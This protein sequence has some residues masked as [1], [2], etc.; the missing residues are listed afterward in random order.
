VQFVQ[1]EELPDAPAK[2][3]NKENKMKK[4]ILMITAAMVAGAVSAA[5]VS[6][7]VDFASAY[8]FRGVT[9]NDGFVM[10]PYAEISGL[11]IPEEYGS[12]AVGIWAN[13]DIDSVGSD[14]SSVSEIDYYISYTLPVELLDISVGYCE[15][16]YPNGGDSD[17]ELSL[18]LG[19]AIGTN[20]LYASVG[21]YYGIGGAIENSWYIQ[22]A[23]DY[24]VSLSDA[25][26]ASAGVSVGY[27]VIDDGESGFNDASVSLGL[28]YALNDTWSL[29]AGVSYVMQ[30]DDDVLTDDAY[31]VGLIGSLGLA[32]DF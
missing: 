15:Y 18:S 14:G 29:S 4:W 1:G 9:L 23:L 28:G 17:Q 3:S 25:L 26:S 16:T 7:G 27:A 32:C 30:L 19:S 22:P 13:Y 12:L 20:G 10:Q 11:P 21:V 8:V 6:A 24:E 5:D 2:Q 31:D